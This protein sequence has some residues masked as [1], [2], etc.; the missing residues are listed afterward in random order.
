[1]DY[2]SIILSKKLT[3]IE[4]VGDPEKQRIVDKFYTRI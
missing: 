1:M 4:V 3:L 2:T